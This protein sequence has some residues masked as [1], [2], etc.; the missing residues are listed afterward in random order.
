MVSGRRQSY[1]P[2]HAAIDP[3]DLELLPS[4]DFILPAKLRGEHN[5]AFGRD[6]SLHGSKISSYPRDGKALSRLI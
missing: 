3:L 1:E 5:L 2:I 4:L 6:R